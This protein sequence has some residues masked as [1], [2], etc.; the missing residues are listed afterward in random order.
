MLTMFR[1]IVV[2]MLGLTMAACSL[3]RPLPEASSLDQRQAAA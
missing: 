3:L 2:A 1:M